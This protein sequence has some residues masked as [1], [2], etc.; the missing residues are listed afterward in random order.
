MLHDLLRVHAGTTW[1]LNPSISQRKKVS[2]NLYSFYSRITIYQCILLILA[3]IE[4]VNVILLSTGTKL[5]FFFDMLHGQ[6]VFTLYYTLCILGPLE[7]A[8]SELLL[9]NLKI[10]GYLLCLMTGF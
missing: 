1:F 5:G 10:G 4:I 8:K 3:I 6:L 7:I 9:K 2:A